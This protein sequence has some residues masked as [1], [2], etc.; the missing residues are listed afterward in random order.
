M[1]EDFKKDLI[2][3]LLCIDRCVKVFKRLELEEIEEENDGVE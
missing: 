2:I 3:L 1:N